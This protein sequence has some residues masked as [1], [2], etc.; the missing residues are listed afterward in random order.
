MGEIAVR[1]VPRQEGRVATKRPQLLRDRIEQLLVIAARKV[2]AA[3]RSLE[4]HIADDRQ[5]R[6]SMVKHHMTGRVAGAV[7]HVERQFAHR[8][9]V[10]MLQPAVRREAF[11]DHPPARA[12]IIQLVDPEA[13]ILVRAFDFEAQ[14]LGQHPGLPAMVEMPV[15]DEDLLQRDACLGDALLELV[16]IPARIDQRA[17]HGLSAP[18]QRA[19]LLQRCHRNDRGAHGGERFGGVGH[20]KGLKPAPPSTQPGR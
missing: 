4:Q 20:D 7:D 14:L 13:V 15:G 12:V 19:V 8:H 9:R 6:R 1:A 10:A 3:D 2:G 16:E 5:L 18:D 11:C 17:F